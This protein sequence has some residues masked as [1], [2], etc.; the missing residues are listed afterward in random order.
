MTRHT[1]RG[2]TPPTYNRGTAWRTTPLPADW[3]TTRTRILARDPRCRIRSHCWGAPSIDVDHIDNPTDHTDTN[4]RGACE[5]CHDARSAG[6]GAEAAKAARAHKVG[7]TPKSHP[8][9]RSDRG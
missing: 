8:G 5:R 4:L 9:L 7:R 6:Q 2:T 3:P 1:P